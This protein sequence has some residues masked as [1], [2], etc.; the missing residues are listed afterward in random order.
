MKDSALLPSQEALID[1]PWALSKS[2]ELVVYATNPQAQISDTANLWKAKA[3]C[4]VHLDLY[5]S[6][7][8]IW[9]VEYIIFL[10]FY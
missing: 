9:Q 10:D 4:L 1:Q 2:E 5:H 8:N 3:L 7:F 6:C